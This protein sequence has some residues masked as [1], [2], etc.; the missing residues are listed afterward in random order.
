M[1]LLKTL[2]QEA[3]DDLNPKLNVLF[4]GDGEVTAPYSFANQ[5]TKTLDIKSKIVGFKNASS[6]QIYKLVKSM[7]PQKKIRNS[8]NT[9]NSLFN[10]IFNFDFT[11]SGPTYDIITIMAGGSDGAPG[12]QRR[13]IRDLQL[14]FELVKESGAKLI[15]I[16]NPTKSYLK[17]DDALYKDHGYPSNDAIGIWVNN[18]T[19]SDAVIDVNSMSKNKF[20]SDN[21]QLSPNAHRDIANE[22][23]S[24]ISSFNLKITPTE[25]TSD[26]IPEV[27][28]FIPSD[29]SDT[30]TGNYN[31]S[32]I[33]QSTELLKR[34]ENAGITA[35]SILTPVWDVN[36]W[37][38][39]YGSSTIT[40]TD[41]KV[42]KLSNNRTKKPNITITGEDASRDLQ[43]RLVNEFIPRTI[44]QL[45]DAANTLS[46]GTIAA[47]V[48]VTYNY[49]SLPRSVVLAAKSKNINQLIAAVRALS[50]DNG[51]INKKRRN[52]EANYIAN[53]EGVGSGSGEQL[54]FTQGENAGAMNVMRFLIDK[55]L[56]VAGAAG[57]AGNM[58]IESNFK[59][60]V[61]GDNGTSIGL[62]QWHYERKDKLFSWAKQNGYDPLSTKGQ[63]EY[64]W[65]E[66]GTSFSKLKS[67]L[68]IIQDPRAAAFQFAKEF[69]RPAN[70]SANRSVY[71]QQYFNE[72]NSATSN[73]STIV[74]KDGAFNGARTIVIGDSITTHLAKAAGFAPG[75]QAKGTG[76]Y[77]GS[78]LW[79]GGIGLGALVKMSAA[80]KTV[81]LDVKNVV[82]TIGTNGYGSTAGVGGLAKN[83]KRI[84]PNAKL[85]VCQ[86]AY[87]PK[88][89]STKYPHLANYT[90]QYISSFYN[91]FAAA[92]ITV[93][94]YPIKDTVL[95]VH[96]PSVPVYKKW[97][98]YIN[99]NG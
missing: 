89:K 84:F 66:L 46:N 35:T 39:G 47:L 78:G 20:A 65:W 57:I 41:G 2:L 75:P 4:V 23:K 63:L 77:S 10:S 16:S 29:G 55:G 8:D 32:I 71:A 56:S 64:L 38:I 73:K 30:I 74:N 13:A 28:I 1:I 25:K 7:L 81:H 80:Y 6:L 88:W 83:L 27:P 21:V 36:N 62:V 12:K 67:D 68:K 99:S 90:D 48:S 42:I 3:A 31:S 19:I 96:A 33:D 70:I 40:M 17:T 26:D 52:K 53:A 85:F 94:P 34:F 97:G 37:R 82:I 72:Y 18:Q 15:A 5:L 60:S 50:A 76:D 91:A 93:V 24:I 9:D 49:G 22:W 87:G 54:Q 44:S 61:L 59:T 69:E 95:N 45:G 58:Q 86:G 11:Q 92:G 43:R 51:G 98:S 14:A 79:F